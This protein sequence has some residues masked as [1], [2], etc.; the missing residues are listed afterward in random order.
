[1][2]GCFQGHKPLGLG[3]LYFWGEIVNASVK[4]IE[5]VTPST[6]AIHV[7][8]PPQHPSASVLGTERMGSGAIIDPAGYILTV[9]YIAIG[10]ST[11]QVTLL[12]DSQ[13]EAEIA[14]YEARNPAPPALQSTR[15]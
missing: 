7:T 2:R 12:D 14:A 5:Q 15:Q 10:A 3:N 6:V 8:V 9:N 4:L 11:V 13:H 1:M